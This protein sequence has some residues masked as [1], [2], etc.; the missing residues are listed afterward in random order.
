M[1]VIDHRSRPNQAKKKKVNLEASIFNYN[2]KGAIA[3][4]EK[5]KTIQ[6]PPFCKKSGVSPC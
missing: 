2:I 3:G 5:D 4:L 6:K 1:K